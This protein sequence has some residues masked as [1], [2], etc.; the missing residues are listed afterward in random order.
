MRR[1]CRVTWGVTAPGCKTVPSP[2]DNLKL[3]RTF[4]QNVAL[5]CRILVSNAARLETDVR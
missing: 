3:P 1:E 2:V 4:T 5:I